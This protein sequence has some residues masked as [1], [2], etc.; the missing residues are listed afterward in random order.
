MAPVNLV[1]MRK[2]DPLP[3]ATVLNRGYLCIVQDT[4][5]DD[6]FY[7]C[8]LQADGSYDWQRV[9]DVVGSLVHDHDA[10]YAE[11]SHDHDADYAAASH[12]HA[13]SDVTGLQTAL[14]GKVDDNP[15]FL[16]LFPLNGEIASGSF[17][18]RDRPSTSAN[19]I[20]SATTGMDLHDTGERHTADSFTWAY[21]WLD[22]VGWGWI[23]T[24]ALA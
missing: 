12:S 20:T 7:L 11:L 24:T 21:I 16:T 18:F 4:G 2:G 9:G 14:D 3:D 22:N 6:E 23:V 19:V 8:A 13:I 17:N 15:T 10:D 5:A 1:V